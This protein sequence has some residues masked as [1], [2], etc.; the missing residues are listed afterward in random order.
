MKN[1]WFEGSLFDASDLDNSV[2]VE[3]EN[4]QAKKQLAMASC[5]FGL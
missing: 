2:K 1:D 3:K 5:F 4:L